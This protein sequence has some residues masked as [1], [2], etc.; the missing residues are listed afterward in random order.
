MGFARVYVYCGKTLDYN[1]WVDNLAAGRTFVSSGA[2]ISLSANGRR[3]GDTIRL[4]PGETRE[5]VVEGA[6]RC[7]SALQRVEIVYNGDIVKTIA[8]Q[9]AGKKIE[10]RERISVQGPGWLAARAF[11]AGSSSWWGQADV[12][13]TSPIYI[14]SG[15][16]RLIR[17]AAVRS[18]IRV[19]Q[20]GKGAAKSS[21]M[22]ESAK[23]KQAVLDYYDKGIAMFEQLDDTAPENER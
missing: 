7:R 21:T 2:V 3:I 16:E 9:G 1:T 23:Q 12:A 6:A 19:L 5:I 18:L 4:A 14:Q 20:A 8:A 11:P 22:Y 17:P 10:Y 15:D 13:H